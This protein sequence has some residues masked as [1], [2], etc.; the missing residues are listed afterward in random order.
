MSSDS[1]VLAI[2][3]MAKVTGYDSEN[4]DWFWAKYDPDGTV[5]AEG[6]PKG[7]VSCHSGMRQ[8]DFGLN[9]IAFEHR[10]QRG[11]SN[12]R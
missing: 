12:V 8:N 5:T 9:L 7:C 3:V 1:E 2:T 11:N 4:G 6:S 10:S